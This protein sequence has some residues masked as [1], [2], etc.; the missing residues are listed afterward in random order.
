MIRRSALILAAAVAGLLIWQISSTARPMP[1]ARIATLTDRLFEFGATGFVHDRYSGPEAALF[2]CVLRGAAL[3]PAQS[4]RYREAFTAYLLAQQELFVRLDADLHLATD[5]RASAPNNTGGTGL[6]GTH[7]QHDLSALAN[8]T[9]MH[10]SLTALPRSGPVH[11][12]RLANNIAKDLTDLMV[13]LAPAVHARAIL[14]PEALPPGLPAEIAAP[15]SRF[16]AGIK[17]AQAAPING[18]AYW[19]ALDDALA[20]YAALAS[21]V[22]DRTRAHQG[23]VSRAVSGR[24]MSLQTVAPRLTQSAPSTGARR[25]DT[26]PCPS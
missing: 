16:Y 17:A 23:P 2:D 24:W 15:F 25:A 14:S 3:T 7:D 18:P 19:A 22:Q 9:D 1:P 10:R 11:R 21:V 13:H 6:P 4:V 8:L 5:F 20:G 26:A 12:I